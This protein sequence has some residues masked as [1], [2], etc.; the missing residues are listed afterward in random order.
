VSSSID[1]V[2]VAYGHY[3][4]T[5]SCLRHLQAQ[6]LDHHVIVVD[7]GSTDD[8]RARVR[9]EW[10]AVQLE[11]IDENRGLPEACNRGVAAGSGEIVVLLNNDV[12][13]RADFLER[14]IAPLR[15]EAVG[16][17]ASLVL[18]ADGR[19]IDSVGVTADSTLAGFQRLHGMPIERA[20]D[21][22]PLLTGPEGTA[23]AYRRSA[24]EQLGG[25]DETMPA[26]MEVFDL[27]LRL[28]HAGWQTAC[29]PEAIGV[30]LGS[31][32]YGRRSR[33]QRRL[34]G[35]GRG[36]LLRRYGVLRGRA[37]P[38]A[39]L[40]EGIVVVGDA[41]I[42]RDLSALG[43]RMAGWRAG[44]GR[45]PRPWPPPAAVDMS[46]DFR[47]SLALRRGAYGPARDRAPS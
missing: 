8:T 6:T 24:W 42:S 25:L 19:S 11:C 29:A 22:R 26:Y 46:I 47:D 4:L 35:F 34:A 27:A 41:L 37:A 14:L 18:Q 38:R 9:S 10:P 17:V 23:G 36:Y 43:G 5:S 33:L 30:H 40:T 39:L 32:T 31:A 15:D 16:S 12:D 13:C 2:V 28:R 3:D 21:S 20:R 7:N 1:V 44:G 45:E